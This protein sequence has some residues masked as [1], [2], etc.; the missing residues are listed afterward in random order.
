MNFYVAPNLVFWQILI[1]FLKTSL[2]VL[3]C[4]ALALIHYLTP[5]EMKLVAA[6]QEFYQLL[7]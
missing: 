6:F 4:L 1:Q 2:V 7:T 5:K 3:A